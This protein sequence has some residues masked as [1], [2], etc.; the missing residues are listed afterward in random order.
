[1]LIIFDS[2]YQFSALTGKYVGDVTNVSVRP[3][4]YRSL[5]MIRLTA[6]QGHYRLKADTQTP[7]SSHRKTSNASLLTEH[8]LQCN[9]P[10]RYNH[11]DNRSI[12]YCEWGNGILLVD[13]V[14]CTMTVTA[15][16][17]QCGKV[18]HTHFGRSVPVIPFGRKLNFAFLY[19]ISE[20]A[21]STKIH[22]E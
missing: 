12:F 20:T 8:H 1:M 5:W 15:H 13:H 4:E 16:I 18:G 11:I 21:A 17:E 9:T 7:Y 3:R 10:G 19:F 14:T 22:F 2:S 6:K